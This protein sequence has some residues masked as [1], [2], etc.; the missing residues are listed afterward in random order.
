MRLLVTG[1]TGFVGTRLALRAAREGHQ[2]T[3]LGR[4]ANADLQATFAHHGVDLRLGDINDAE[5]VSDAVSRSSHVCHLAAAWREVGLPIEHYRRVNVGG[6]R[7]VA[8][9]AARHGVSKFVFC[10][11]VGL[12]PRQSPEVITEE[13]RLDITNPYEASKAETEELLRATA[14]ETGLS[15]TVLRPADVYGPGDLRLLKLFRG[16]AR[17]R[18]PLVGAGTGRRHMLFI[19]DLAGA[20]L[21][22]CE[23]DSGSCESFIIAGPEVITLRALLELL[24][25]LLAVRRFGFRVPFGPMMAAAAVIEDVCGVIGVTPPIHRRSLDFFLTDVEYDTGKARRTLQW[26]PLVSLDSGLQQ[27]IDWYR[28]ERL[29]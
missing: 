21:A 4:N 22:A 9:A 20:L 11:T 15:I 18:F 16:V 2:V 1:A 14:R 23:R 3:A 26:T 17:Q 24:T 29:L 13:S 27:T 19:D 28:Q 7:N 5:F 12:H 8:L 6:T 10:S 25:K